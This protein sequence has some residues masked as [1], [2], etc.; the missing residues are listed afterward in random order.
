M[1]LEA[2]PET[3]ICIIDHGQSW[4]D[5]ILK[6]IEHEQESSDPKDRPRWQGGVHRRTVI[7]G[8]LFRRGVSMF[9]LKCIEGE[10]VD[11]VLS[12]IHEGICGKHRG[13]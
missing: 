1:S 2:V 4:I 8:E 9:L 7:E 6:Y 11:Y 10:E 13:S 3:V 12:E 5:P